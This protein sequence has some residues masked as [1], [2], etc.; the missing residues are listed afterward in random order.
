[1][2]F[3]SNV[4]K[5]LS[6]Q[7]SL[8]VCNMIQL[9]VVSIYTARTNFILYKAQKE[10]KIYSFRLISR[11]LTLQLSHNIS[12]SLRGIFSTYSFL[13]QT[14]FITQTKITHPLFPYICQLSGI[15][16]VFCVMLHQTVVIFAAHG[17]LWK[18]NVSAI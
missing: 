6:L 2:F 14:A 1:M 11:F 18:S 7:S 3:P 5:L 8:R 15:H 4:H 17:L 9:Q 16:Y 13:L 10:E 12:I